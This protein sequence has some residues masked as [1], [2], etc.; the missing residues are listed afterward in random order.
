MK[1]RALILFLAASLLPARV[2]GQGAAKPPKPG[3]RRK[4]MPPVW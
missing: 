2:M 4:L 3:K 1:R